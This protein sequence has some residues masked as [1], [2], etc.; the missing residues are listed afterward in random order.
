MFCAKSFLASAVMTVSLTGIAGA[1]AT[2]PPACT[3]EVHDDFDFWLGEW[4][5][6]APTT[7]DR[8]GPYVGHNVI[9]RVHGGCLV[10]ENWLSVDGS[11]GESMNMYDP[12]AGAWRQVWMSNGWFIDYTGGLDENG[13]MVLMGESYT[14]QTD[15]RAGMRGTWTLQEDGT[16]SQF[17]EQMDAEGNWQGVFMGIY[18]RVEDDPRAAEAAEARGN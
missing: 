9:E 16:V 7:E 1:Q 12:L 11:T 4:N 6:Y 17:F 3:G 10:T 14:E 5:V 13:A 8:P 15:S 2:P 18:V